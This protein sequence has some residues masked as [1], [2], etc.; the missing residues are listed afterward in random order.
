MDNE[1]VK[2]NFTMVD[3]PS[4]LISSSREVQEYKGIARRSPFRSLP[5]AILGIVGSFAR[6]GPSQNYH[7]KPE[8][9]YGPCDLPG[10]RYSHPRRCCMGT[11][12]AERAESRTRRVLLQ[13]T[14]A[15]K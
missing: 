13:K 11:M 7:G 6:H 8:S 3:E 4:S 1:A 5:S 10:W 15:R 12:S 2:V 9:S 14:A